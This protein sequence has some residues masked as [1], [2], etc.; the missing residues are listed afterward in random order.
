M[1]QLFSFLGLGF[2]TCT[3]VL[4]CT[5]E[6]VATQ[7]DG[8][9]SLLTEKTFKVSEEKAKDALALVMDQFEPV[10]TYGASK[11]TVKDVQA[12]R[13]GKQPARTYSSNEALDG[14]LDLD[15]NDIDT[16]LYIMN[17]EEN[18]G[19]ALVSAD[20]RTSSVLAIIDDG[21]MTP[22]M[23]DEMDNPGFIAV[24]NNTT[25]MLL[26]EIA[27]YQEEAPTYASSAFDQADLRTSPIQWD[28]AYEIPVRLKTKWGPRE[29][30]NLYW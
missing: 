18:K 8:D 14:V 30:Y 17:F 16:L 11:R 2:I 1:K 22:E 29:P 21:F 15:L 5:Y 4:S 10:A 12:W 3:F 27:T 26:N 28:L 25:L 20:S 7:V 6:E 24:F 19:F 13:I 9:V 23:L